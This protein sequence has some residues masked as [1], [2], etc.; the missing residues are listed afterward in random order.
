MFVFRQI[1]L[2]ALNG[3]RLRGFLS[4]VNDCQ[5]TMKNLFCMNTLL[6]D[7]KLR[8]AFRLI[9]IILAVSVQY[10]RNTV[11]LSGKCIRRFAGI[12]AYCRY[13]IDRNW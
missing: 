11:R 8:S 7:A 6:T 9:N 12:Y 3:L 13:F 5:L 10:S 2:V 4:Q 1:V